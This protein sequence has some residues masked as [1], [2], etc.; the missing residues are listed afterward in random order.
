M[1]YLTRFLLGGLALMAGCTVR[2]VPE[3]LPVDSSA[4][5][6]ATSTSPI[7]DP[8][9][10]PLAEYGEEATRLRGM[11]LAVSAALRMDTA[12]MLIIVDS[13]PASL[14]TADDLGTLKGRMTV[15]VAGVARATL[16]DSYDELR[17]GTRKHE[18]LDILAPR[19]TPVLSAD[20]GRVLKLFTSK[21]GGLMIYAADASERFILMY[22]HLD[23][24][25]PGLADGQAL[26]TGQ[27]V[28]TVGTSGNAPPGTPH[29]HF[30]VARSTDVKT[31]WKGSPVNPYPLLAP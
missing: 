17:G 19:G 24:Y 15:P 11:P 8:S 13:T 4:L 16:R 6:P 3:R 21:A 12:S 23:A 10:R 31:W 18:G 28:G 7:A 25:A 20:N 26:R 30:A 29:L 14:P 22:A 27:Q 9:L 5:A 2:D 1:S